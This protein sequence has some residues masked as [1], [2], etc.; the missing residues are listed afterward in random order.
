MIKTTLN[1]LCEFTF[2]TPGIKRTTSTTSYC[3]PRSLSFNHVR[4]MAHRPWREPKASSSSIQAMYINNIK[5]EYLHFYPNFK[6]WF[7]QVK[8]DLNLGWTKRGERTGVPIPVLK[9]IFR[10]SGIYLITNTITNKRY[11]GKSSNLFDR[12]T[13]YNS[14]YYLK[15][16]PNSLICKS[17]LKFGFANFS[18]TILEFCQEPD[19]SIREQHFIDLIKP[20]L[21]IRK[22][23]CRSGKETS[24]PTQ[25]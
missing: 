11:V 3:L 14:L 19:L 22:S 2:F 13:N 1:K 4:T 20:Q 17:L 25:T 16:K 7:K 8:W 24:N 18:V 5:L 21:N 23:T 9:Q 12:F 15:S 10:K 6:I